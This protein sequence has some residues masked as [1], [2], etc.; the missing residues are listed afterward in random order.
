MLHVLVWQ[1]FID[2]HRNVF[3]S[4]SQKIKYLKKEIDDCQF[5]TGYRM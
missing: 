3:V 5:V 2:I 4:S 1:K